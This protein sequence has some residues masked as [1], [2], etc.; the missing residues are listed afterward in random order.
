MHTINE[1]ASEILKKKINQKIT[2]LKKN[3]RT[4]N[5]YQDSPHIYLAKTMT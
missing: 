3:D 2:S 5:G 1:G 4:V